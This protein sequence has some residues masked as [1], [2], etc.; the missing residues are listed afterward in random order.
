MGTNKFDHMKDLISIQE[1][2]KKLFED[3]M[4][5]G[6]DGVFHKSWSP[7]VDIYETEDEFVVKAEMPEVRREDVEIEIEN[8]VLII[9]GERKFQ[10]EG[11]K[12]NFHRIERKYGLFKR[13]FLLPSSVDRDNIKAGLKDGVLEIILYKKPETSPHRIKIE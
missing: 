4:E 6:D 1:R 2:V 10:K 7:L 5:K 3:V 9:K 8:N 12:D 11:N 13:S